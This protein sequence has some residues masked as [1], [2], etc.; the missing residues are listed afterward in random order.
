MQWGYILSVRFPA[1]S[2]F[3]LFCFVL[4]GKK[5]AW[6]FDLRWYSDTAASKSQALNENNENNRNE[7]FLI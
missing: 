5:I 2:T 1:L 4:F 3:V 6:N 7:Y